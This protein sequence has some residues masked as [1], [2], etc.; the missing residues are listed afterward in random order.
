MFGRMHFM[1]RRTHQLRVLVAPASLHERHLIAVNVNARIRIGARKFD[2]VLQLLSRDVRKRWRNR[3]PD[4]AMTLRANLDS[5]I[6]HQTR[7][8][9]DGMRASR[10]RSRFQSLVLRMLST[11]P[12]A[13]LAR[14][15]QNKTRFFIVV[16]GL[17]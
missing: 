9:H 12:V 16:F 15:A 8:I 14:D 5:P 6:P 4:P 11:R 7:R 2:V 17:L 10:G 1:T 13:F 3:L